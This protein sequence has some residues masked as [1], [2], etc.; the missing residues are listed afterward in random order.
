MKKIISFIGVI[1]FP[2]WEF[3]I[4]RLL[5]RL[6]LY[7]ADEK[8]E[9]ELI[10]CLLDKR[11]SLAF[12]IISF[13]IAFFLGC[14][15]TKIITGKNNHLE[16]MQESFLKKCSKSILVNKYISIEYDVD[17]DPVFPSPHNLI[18]RCPTCKI[19]TT[20]I[21][22]KQC[23]NANICEQPCPLRQLPSDSFDN[24]KKHHK[25]RIKSNLINEWMEFR[26]L[27]FIKRMF[28]HGKTIAP[29]EF[30]KEN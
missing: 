14:I 7:L 12:F 11:Y 28:W 6:T 19:N 10:T 3:I 13:L 29:I 21:N 23:I 15:I 5:E 9:N 26:G 1:G 4:N 27:N 8:I 20:M 25:D 30:K 17:S 2:V 24:F 16:M 18:L 22:H